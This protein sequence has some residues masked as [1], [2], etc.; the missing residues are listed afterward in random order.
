MTIAESPFAGLSL[1]QFAQRFRERALS[2]RDA[3]ATLLERIRALEPRLRAFTI[4]DEAR[5]LA[6]AEAVDRL[7]H[8][9]V[10]LGPL[11]GVPFAVK[12]LYGVDGLPTGAGSRV[13]V[14]DIAPAQGTLVTRLQRA[15][16]VL[17]GKTRTTE[18]ALGGFNLREAPPWNPCD[19][20]VPRMTGGSSHGSAVAMAAQLAGFTL[21]SDT[22]G[23]VRWPAALC[24]VVGYKATTGH[25]P[26]DGVFPLSRDM[27]SLGPFTAS[28]A[29]AIA[30]EAGVTG[31]PPL[32]AK[33]PGA[34]V[35]ALPGEH[36]AQNIDREVH[37][38]FAHAVEMLRAAGATIVDL[39]LPES[40][41]IDE[42]FSRLVTAEWLAFVGRERFIA[43]EALMDPVAAARIR[44]GLDLRADEYV[45]LCA[46]RDELVERVRR[47]G[48]G[49]DGWISPTVVTLP[50][51]C[52]EFTTV[53]AAAAWNRV[54]T[55]NTRPANLFGQCGI[56]LPMHQLGAPLPAGFQL[57]SAP[58]TDRALLAAALAIEAVLGRA[59]LPSLTAWT[60]D[61]AAA[62]PASGSAGDGVG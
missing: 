3:T 60:K 46:R 17:L 20:A 27:D 31:V 14:S 26:Q 12:D 16:C 38:C 44:G 51:P 28:V 29:D 48:E 47:R 32:P 54:N 18:F 55:Q 36:F 61:A 33:R 11:M 34:L 8:A 53:E 30:I 10:D 9:G 4:V 35:L 24:G 39:P 37:D 57:F 22:G 5:A 45:R 42:V 49:I 19:L 23:S 50:A 52:S 6:Q 2:A 58:G 1:A 43:N 7:R 41:E 15:G 13:D 59:P 25:W 21:G 40:R 62:A 56:S